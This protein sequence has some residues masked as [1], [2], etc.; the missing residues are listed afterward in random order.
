MSKVVQSDETAPA[1]ENR[2]ANKYT[3]DASRRIAM[4]QAM[5]ED[6][7]YHAD[8]RALSPTQVRLA[9]HTSVFALEKAAVF[10]E[11]AP[12]IGLS[13][14]EPMELRDVIAYEQAYGGVRDAALALARNI[15]R[16]ILRRKLKAVLSV[17]ALYRIAKGYATVNAGDLVHTHLAELKRALVVPRRRKTAAPEEKE[18]M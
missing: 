7:V 5:A 16:G 3:L 17:R 18:K 6:F 2:A 11:A 15:D 10:A 4:L 9:R 12:Q 13:V 1:A 8:P 14:V